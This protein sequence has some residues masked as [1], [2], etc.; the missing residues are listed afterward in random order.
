MIRTAAYLAAAFVVG[1]VLATVALVVWAG[2]ALA[3]DMT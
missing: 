1:W 3:G 2:H